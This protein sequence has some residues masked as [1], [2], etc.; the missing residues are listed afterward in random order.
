MI[1]QHKME[2]RGLILA[3]KYKF[4]ERTESTDQGLTR[5]EA[6]QPIEKAEAE[7][8]EEILTAD[9]YNAVLHKRPKNK[10]K[11]DKTFTKES[12]N[13]QSFG[14]AQ[15]AP[16]VKLV[17]CQSCSKVQANEDDDLKDEKKIDARPLKEQNKVIDSI[18]MEPLKEEPTAD[19]PLKNN[20]LELI[21]KS[22][23]APQT[24]KE[25]NFDGNL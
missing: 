10:L 16:V 3:E 15:F 21:K 17:I 4:D 20:F 23:E 1:K 18:Q 14:N 22:A 9:N 2:L 8:E 7:V 24:P 25:D 12:V 19:D 5:S 6:S 11:R 13:R